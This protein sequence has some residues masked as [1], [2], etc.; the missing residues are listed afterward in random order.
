MATHQEDIESRG[1]VLFCGDFNITN[2]MWGNKSTKKT[3]YRA[4]KLMV[5]MDLLFL[6]DDKTTRMAGLQGDEDSVI[7]LDL[8]SSAFTLN[9]YWESLGHHDSG[10]RKNDFPADKQN[11]LIFVV[12]YGG[13]LVND[14]E[15]LF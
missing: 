9:C 7:D 6:N 15:G 8:A 4:R 3:G 10:N 12:I 11:T 1:N 13:Q 14:N 2:K 5:N